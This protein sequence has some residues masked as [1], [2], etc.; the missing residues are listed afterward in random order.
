[1]AD[2]AFLVPE[3]LHLDM[4]GIQ[5]QAL[6]IQCI[7]PERPPGFP[8]AT[9][10]GVVQ[11]VLPVNR[12]HTTA[13]SAGNGLQHHASLLAMGLFQL[14]QKTAGLGQIDGAVAALGQWDTALG[15]QLPR[16]GLVA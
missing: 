2:V 13:A 8:L 3:Y 15:G 12:P 7:V 1:M 9:V 10:P 5:Q 14:L 4:A 6:R 16:P 11:L